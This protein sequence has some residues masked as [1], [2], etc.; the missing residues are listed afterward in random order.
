MRDPSPLQ[1]VT[2]FEL[3]VPLLATAFLASSCGTPAPQDP[4]CSIAPL[5]GGADIKAGQGALQVEGTTSAYFYV[6]DPAG[7][8]V[9][10]QTLGKTLALEPGKY[11]LKVNNSAHTVA[12]ERGKL[13]SCS[14]GALLMSG[15]TS[16]YWYVQDTTGKALQHDTLGKAISLIPGTF[17]LKVN[18]T[19]VATEVKLNQTTEIKTGTL[20]V[21]GGTNEYYYAASTGK[22]LNHNTLEKPLAFLPGSYTVKVN[23]TEAKADIVAGEITELKTGTL[24]VKGLTDEYYYVIDSAG[25]PLSHQSI[26]KTLAFFPGSYRVLVNKTEKTVDVAAAQ[27][28][29]TQTGSLVVEAAGSDYYY[30]SD[31]TGNALSHNSVNKALSF[32]PAEYNVKLGQTTRPASVEAGQTTRVKH[33]Q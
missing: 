25:K 14:T 16:E 18:N 7:K 11:Q 9:N 22:A 30:V 32:F 13:T 20:V 8:P 17:R 23:N 27:T 29:E 31:K 28:V 5:P 24:V 33:S 12:V 1:R 15:T 3:A 4:Y 21:R 26:N 2:K 6:L 19:E 10:H